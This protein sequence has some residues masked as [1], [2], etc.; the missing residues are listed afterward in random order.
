MASPPVSIVRQQDGRHNVVDSSGQV[1]GKHNSV[2]SAAR[3]IHEYFQ[4]GP[5][6]A[7]PEPKTKKVHGVGKPVIPRPRIPRP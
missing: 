3:Q 6:E 7:V 2:F 5:A 4:T 1:L